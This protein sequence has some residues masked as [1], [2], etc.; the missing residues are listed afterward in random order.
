MPTIADDGAMTT[1]C[2]LVLRAIKGNQASFGIEFKAERSY[3][4]WSLEL[5]DAGEL[6]VDVVGAAITSGPASRSTLRHEVS[7]DIGVRK[8][9]GIEDSKATNGRI[10]LDEKD[11]LAKFVLDIHKFL[12]SHGQR[13]IGTN[14]TWK[15]TELRAVY[16]AEHLKQFRQFTGI[17]RAI[18]TV[19]EEI[20]A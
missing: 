19:Y 17:M 9:F 5:A 8:R 4:D 10:E 12:C 14:I 13:Q 6:R 16:L 11:R 15:S 3:A 18:Y 7:I 20:D 2:E 1:A